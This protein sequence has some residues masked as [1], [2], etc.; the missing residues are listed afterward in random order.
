MKLAGVRVID[1]SVFMPGPS[2]QLC[3]SGSLDM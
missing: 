3:H 2:P 1:L